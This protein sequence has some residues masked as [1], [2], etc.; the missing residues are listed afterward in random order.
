MTFRYKKWNNINITTKIQT[1][2]LHSHFS[3]HNH[4]SPFAV[5]VYNQSSTIYTS[6]STFPAPSQW[7]A[8]GCPSQLI[9]FC[10]CGE[11]KMFLS[12]VRN[13]TVYDR[14]PYDIWPIRTKFFGPGREFFNPIELG[15]MWSVDMA[16][17]LDKLLCNLWWKFQGH[18]HISYIRTFPSVENLQ[19]NLPVRES[20]RKHGYHTKL[21]SFLSW[22]MWNFSNFMEFVAFGLGG[23]GGGQ[24]KAE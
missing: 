5:S 22:C 19:I 18:S 9:F 20:S 17:R 6:S 3:L 21:I 23:G 4:S 16:I 8:D 2:S 12:V 11:E 1:L 13:D 14:K 15:Q 7:L 24:R 10:H